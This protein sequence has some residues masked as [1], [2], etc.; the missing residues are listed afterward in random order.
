MNSTKFEAIGTHWNIDID[1][2]ASVDVFARIRERIEIFESAYSRFRANSL[3]SKMSR[4]AGTYQLPEDAKP[5]IDLYEKLYKITGGA[6]TPLIGSLLAEAGY[7]SAYSLTPKELHTPPK[8][9]DVLDYHF[10]TLTLKKPAMLDFGS[11]GKGYAIDLVGEMLD[12]Q[13]IH[14][15]C[16]DAGGDMRYRNTEGKPLRIGLEDPGNAGKVIGVATIK[17]ESLCGSAGNRRAWDKFHHIMDPRTLGSPRHLLTAWTVADSTL[18]ADAMATC[19][20]L[21]SPTDLLPHFD[22]EYLILRPDYTV[23]MSKGFPG[24]VFEAGQQLTANG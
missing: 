20:F 19:L 5:M 13:G 11:L 21:V 17:N 10:P 23:E 8:W 16:V 18:I 24:E 14:S 22:F 4:E 6:F 3:V 7:D 1:G 2:D 9:D 12:Q 15:Y